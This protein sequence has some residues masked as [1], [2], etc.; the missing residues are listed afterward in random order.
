MIARRIREVGVY[1]E[2]H[3]FNTPLS[4]LRG[5]E[6]RGIVLS[7]GPSSVYEDG[8]PHCSPEILDLGVPVLGICY[9]FQLISH[10][11]GG[12]VEASS[13]REYGAAELRKLAGGRLL[14]G[15]PESFPVWMSHGDH[16]TQPPSGFQVVAESDNALGAVENAG[17]GIYA[18][19][20]HPEVAHT[21]DGKTIL[22]NFVRD[23]CGCRGDWSAASFIHA[24]VEKIRDQVGDGRAVCGL[25]GGVDSTVAAA[26]VTRAIGARLTCIFVDNGLLRKNEFEHVLNAFS[27]Y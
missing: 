2:I 8:A 20:F 10:F 25:S 23:I 11:L 22:S 7:G 4:T 27:G 6:P 26:L 3:P 16:V 13:R 1:C 17:R 19:Q 18:L 24:S 9:G 15:L 5:L 14:K 12:K 21:P